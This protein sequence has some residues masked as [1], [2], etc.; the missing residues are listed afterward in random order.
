[1][2]SME[3]RDGKILLKVFKSYLPVVSICSLIL[4]ADIGRN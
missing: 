4:R 2:L 1:M 3:L